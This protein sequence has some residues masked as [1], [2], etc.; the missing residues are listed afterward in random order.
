MKIVGLETNKEIDFSIAVDNLTL[1]TPQKQDYYTL[2]L[3]T[4]GHIDLKVGNHN[5]TVDE[6][7]MSIISP[8]VIYLG[9]DASPDFRVFQIFFKKCFL[10]RNYVKEMIVDELLFLN[11]DYPPVYKLGDSFK[12]VLQNFNN[13]AWELDTKRPYHLNIIRLKL[14]EILYDYNR[15]CEYCLLGFHKGMNR[16]YQ[17]TYTFK[18]HLEEKFKELKTVQQYAD[19]MGITPKHLTEVIKEETGMTALQLIHERLLLEAQYLLRHSHMTVK[20][21]AYELG[22][23]NIS[24][25]NRFF[26]LHIGDSPLGYRNK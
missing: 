1:T 6:G 24:Y 17:L 16:Q 13:L 21:C 4:R 14:I 12:Q 26:K 23:D 18:Q 8:E 10:Y 20:E 7:S 5:F 11:A 19:L 22:F 15:A 9:G 25:F 2:I 3:C